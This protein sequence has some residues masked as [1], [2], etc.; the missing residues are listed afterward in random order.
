MMNGS[1]Q[2]GFVIPLALIII[3]ILVAL[4]MGLSHQAKNQMANL[5]RQQ[6]QWQSELRYRSVL[7]QLIHSL[8]TGNI[9]YNK[10]QTGSLQIPLDGRP[11]TLDGVEVSVQD[12]SGLLSLAINDQDQFYRLLLQLTD[13]ESAQKISQEFTD[14]IDR[15][16]LPQR[17]GMELSNYI[18]AGLAYQPRNKMI[19]SLDELLELP[20]M[21]YE[22][23]NG[24]SKY[25]ALRNL[26]VPG[27]VALNLNAATAPKQV[28]RALLNASDEQWQAIWTARTAENWPQLQKLL[29]SFPGLF[30]EIGP[31][32]ASTTYRFI[33]KIP[34]QKAFRATIKLLPHAQPPYA[35]Q[36][37]YYPD[38]PRGLNAPHLN[39]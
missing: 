13:L 14:W 16:S 7:Q 29:Q 2:R 4:A 1:R 32:F 9:T 17:H 19:R 36:Q 37:W 28:L 3:S 18:Q 33:L 22:L 27:P 35:I 39:L 10:V 20:S 31:F 24:S 12:A 38:D 6:E 30:N 21:T 25:P 15:N 8:L 34:G 26:V 5:Q 11:I 23:F